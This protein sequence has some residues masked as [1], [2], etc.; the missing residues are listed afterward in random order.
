M[1]KIVISLLFFFYGLFISQLLNADE[2]EKIYVAS[3]Q[4]E[5]EDNCIVILLDGADIPVSALRHDNDGLY[6]LRSEISLLTSPRSW[7]CRNCGYD[8][9]FWRERCVDCNHRRQ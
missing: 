1:K 8:N 6:F 5:I 4:I 2:D 7:I 3:E 9:N